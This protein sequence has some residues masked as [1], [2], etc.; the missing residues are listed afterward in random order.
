MAAGDGHSILSF[1]NQCLQ[2][3]LGLQFC[4]P[5][6]VWVT[7]IRTYIS[8]VKN[9]RAGCG[10]LRCFQAIHLHRT[11]WTPSIRYITSTYR[12][13]KL[14]LLLRLPSLRRASGI[15]TLSW[16]CHTK[17]ERTRVAGQ[18]PGETSRLG[19]AFCDT[20]SLIFS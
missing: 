8:Y 4:F 15:V 7:P 10:E 19:H 9:T 12:T 11:A 20:T 3:S 1:Q 2:Q 5:S 17:K 18:A 16:L 13:I 6:C 14:Q